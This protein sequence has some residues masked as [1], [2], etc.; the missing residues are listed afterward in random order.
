M[1][2]SAASSA[3]LEAADRLLP[4]S[5]LIACSSRCSASRK[6]FDKTFRSSSSFWVKPLKMG[7]G[8]PE[9]SMDFFLFRFPSIEPILK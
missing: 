4:R 6:A 3:S 9:P 1:S 7:W 5:S 2:E 8:I